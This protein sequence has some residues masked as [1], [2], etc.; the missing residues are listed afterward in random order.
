MIAEVK[1]RP[2]VDERNELLAFGHRRKVG[3]AREGLA[4]RDAMARFSVHEL[5][6]GE[7]AGALVCVKSVGRSGRSA[8]AA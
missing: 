1:V 6:M 3:V 5:I 4:S 8:S 7:P 2:N